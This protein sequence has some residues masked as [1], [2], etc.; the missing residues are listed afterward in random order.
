[1]S[2][3]GINNK[4]SVT[5]PRMDERHKIRIAVKW[6]VVTR[7][8]LQIPDEDILEPLRELQKSLLEMPAHIIRF[9]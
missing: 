3:E 2:K 6:P 9:R 7:P 1:M 4:F 8:D 5:E